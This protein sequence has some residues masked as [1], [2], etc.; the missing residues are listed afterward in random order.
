MLQRLVTCSGFMRTSM[1]AGLPLAVRQPR[2]GRK[3]ILTPGGMVNCGASVAD[4][5]QAKGKRSP[6]ALLAFWAV[7]M[8]VRLGARSFKPK[9]WSTPMTTR[10]RKCTAV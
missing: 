8:V 10:R 9:L 2:G 6:K 5:T 4:T 7:D 1:S 3:L